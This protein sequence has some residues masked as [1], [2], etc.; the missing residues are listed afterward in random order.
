MNYKDFLAY[1]GE[2]I[3]DYLEDIEIKKI[4]IVGNEKNNGVIRDELMVQS[5]HSDYSTFI[6][7]EPFFQRYLN[8]SE[9]EQ[10][11]EEL[12]DT[13]FRHMALPDHHFN[14]E[15]EQLDKVRDNIFF[16]VISFNENK[17]KLKEW[18]Y[19]QKLD[20]ALVFKISIKWEQEGIM[21][22]SVT[23]YLLE[24]WHISLEELFNIAME[25]TVKNYPYVFTSMGMPDTDQDKMMY[26]LTNEE[27]IN[28]A[29]VMFYPN[30]LETI[31]GKLNKD[32]YVLPS[33]I[34]EVLIVPDSDDI[35]GSRL[36]SIVMEVNETVVSQEEI[37][38]NH[39]Y[40]YSRDNQQLEIFQ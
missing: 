38:S 1:I 37:L 12:S 14:M 18:P 3:S 31:G 27:T 32:F 26:V 22:L 24:Q 4:E 39:V 5:S 34:H 25:N 36:Q 30:I 40:L 20:L 28:G 35:H 15:I 9:L 23:N 7:L 2:N 11:L 29:S 8:G 6:D 21:S 17:D 33:S 10:L 19:I 13:Y 16:R